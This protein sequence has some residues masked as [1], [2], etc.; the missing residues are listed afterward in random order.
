MFKKVLIGIGASIYG[1]LFAQVSDVKINNQSFVLAN[2]ETLSFLSTHVDTGSWNKNL[3]TKGFKNIKPTT[4]NISLSY[5]KDTMGI[6]ECINYENIYE[7]LTII[8]KDA[9]GKHVITKELK[10]TLKKN[11]YN[12]SGTYKIEYNSV[13]YIITYESNKD[14]TVYEM[15]TVEK[16]KK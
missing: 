4:K 2:M 1:S 13:N 3:G 14:K 12:S 8:W 16:E 15:I 7:V 10:K 5:V 6:Y 11:E 9:S